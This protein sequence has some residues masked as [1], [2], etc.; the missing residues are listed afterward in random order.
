[1]RTFSSGRLRRM[2]LVGSCVLLSCVPKAPE[3]TVVSL[4]APPRDLAEI[5]ASG[6]LRILTRN[7]PQT[8]FLFRGRELGF[9]YELAE[10]FATRLGVK[11]RAVVPPEWTDLIPWLLEGKGDLIASA[12]TVTPGR[13]AEIAF[14]VPYQRI[15]EVLVGRRGEPIPGSIDDLVGRAV[16]VREGS[17]YEATLLRLKLK[18]RMEFSVEIMPPH[19]ET[20]D[21]VA[22]LRAGEIDLTV[23]DQNIGWFERTY[24]NDIV[25][26]PALTEPRPI[27]WG[28]RPDCPSLLRAA[29]EYLTS[30]KKTTFFNYLVKKYYLVP[31]NIMR[32]RNSLEVT[33][34]KGVISRYDRY[35]KGSAE[36]HDI[37]WLLV[38]ALIYQESRFDPDRESWAGAIGLAQLLPSTAREL[39]VVDPWDPAQNIEGGVRYLKRM[40]DR[41]ESTTEEDRVPLALASYCAGLGHVLDARS[42]ATESGLDPHIWE[43]NVEQTL[44]LLS[45]PEYYKKARH[46]YAR[47]DEAVS[48]ANDIVRRWHAYTTLVGGEDPG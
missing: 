20:S 43:G 5:K 39:G 35:I 30:M 8:Y 11:V 12:M 42:L 1:M 32:H 26:G 19:M 25:L 2:L 46:G 29:N 15:P 38:A 37:D 9:E 41:F 6:E 34:E 14:T 3:I 48:Y 13:A 17:S 44:L 10:E 36:R 47:G 22:M 24:S 4:P 18:K 33:K 45:R 23:A 7:N 16:H 21:I 28:V 31:K 27:A 40:Y